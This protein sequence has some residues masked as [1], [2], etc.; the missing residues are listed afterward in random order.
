V[1]LENADGRLK[2]NIFAQMRFAVA[3]IPGSSE[4]A[5]SALVSD[6]AK[7]FVYVQTAEGRFTRR[8]VVAGSAREGRVP[9]L[10]GL[11]AGEVVVEEGAIL[12]DNQVALA[13]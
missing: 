5:A 13:H 1:R 4:V 9:I 11:S 8:E 7:Q 12:L 3:P 6:G 2:P 10:K